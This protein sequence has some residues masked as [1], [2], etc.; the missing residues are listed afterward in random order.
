MPQVQTIPILNDTDLFDVQGVAF[1]P[2]RALHYKLPVLG[3]RVGGFTY[4]TDANYLSPAA[5]DQM[6]GSDV[7]VLNALRQEVLA[8][9]PTRDEWVK[10]NLGYGPSRVGAFRDENSPADAPNYILR[11]VH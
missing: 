9:L 4:V 6:R 2:I 3:F 1:Q 10:V 5:R 11:V 7:I 8:L